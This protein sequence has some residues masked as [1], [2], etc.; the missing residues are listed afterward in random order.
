[1]AIYRVVG[2]GPGW[3]TLG[4]LEPLPVV[5]PP[6]DPE[7]EP[8]PAPVDWDA[9]FKQTLAMA[10]DFATAVTAL[11]NARG[12]ITLA[13]QAQDAAASKLTAL[14]TALNEAKSA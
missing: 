8:P 11:A 7:P 4:A 5:D 13:S 9:L 12:Q 2:A 6:P 1:M 10:V 3:A 14:L